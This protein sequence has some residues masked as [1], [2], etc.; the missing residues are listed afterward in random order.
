M[1]FLHDCEIDLQAGSL[2]F[3]ISSLDGTMKSLWKASM[4]AQAI[5]KRD[6]FYGT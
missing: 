4:Q 5:A 2:M 3:A 1:A 6:D